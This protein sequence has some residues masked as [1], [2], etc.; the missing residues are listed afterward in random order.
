MRKLY[1]FFIPRFFNAEIKHL[2]ENES[3]I[4][5]ILMDIGENP[6]D[7]QNALQAFYEC[8]ENTRTHLKKN[9][10]VSDNYNWKKGAIIKKR[11]STNRNLQYK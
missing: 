11:Y 3:D 7:V 5:R 6:Q 2:K 9:S 10:V 8:Y 1:V 4:T